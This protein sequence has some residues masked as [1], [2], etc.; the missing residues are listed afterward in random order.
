V[1]D[2]QGKLVGIVSESDLLHR[3][4]TGT[5]PQRS[6]WLHLFTG[7]ELLAEEY[8][9]AHARRVADIMTT[10]VVTATPDTPLGEIAAT[11]EKRKIKRVPIVEGEKPVGIVS[12]ANLVQ[13]LASTQ[14]QASMPASENDAVL[15]EHLFDRLKSESWLSSVTLNIIV[16][17]GTVDL[18]GMVSSE[19]ERKAILIAAESTPGVRKINDHL[20]VG[21][22]PIGV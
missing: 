16:H 22:L 19:A 13:A 5:V 21:S 9:K 1:V 8:V 20:V 6:W 10:K 7:S 4:E 11:L 18:W 14:L 2:E 3:T 17:D 12:R 15:R